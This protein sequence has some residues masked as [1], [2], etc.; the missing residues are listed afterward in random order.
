MVAY[1]I[2]PCRTYGCLFSS[3]QV[4]IAKFHAHSTRCSSDGMHC[5]SNSACVIQAGRFRDSSI[6]PICFFSGISS[7]LAPFASAWPVFMAPYKVT[8]D[9]Q[10][11]FESCSVHK[12]DETW[13]SDKKIPARIYW[14]QSSV[15][16][17]PMLSGK[18]NFNCP[19]MADSSALSARTDFV[20]YF[21]K[22]T[23]FSCRLY[24]GLRCAMGVNCFFFPFF[25]VLPVHLK[26]AVAVINIVRERRQVGNNGN[27]ANSPEAQTT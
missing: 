12:S 2:F 4:Y 3:R 24:I 1:L 13:L 22:T 16:Y 14:L 7:C 5:S 20:L 10:L 8:R 27:P 19:T 17:L 6:S 9:T 23:Q 26:K 21:S 11:L 15:F 18:K 25:S